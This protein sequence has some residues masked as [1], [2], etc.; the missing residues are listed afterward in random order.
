MA[1]A[2]PVHNLSPRES[3]LAIAIADERVG[4]SERARALRL[5]E[6]IESYWRDRGFAVVVELVDAGFDPA[7][8]GARVDLRSKLKNGQPTEEGE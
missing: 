5:K 1:R 8:R 4:A 2:R 3:S 7:V 6:R